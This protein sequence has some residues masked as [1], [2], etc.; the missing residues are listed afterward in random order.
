LGVEKEITISLLRSLDQKRNRNGRNNTLCLCQMVSE[1]T[2][3]KL[4]F[5]AVKLIFAEETDKALKTED[6]FC[7]GED[8]QQMAKKQKTA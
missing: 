5:V 4:N 2:I 8:P 3:N 7:S 1:N 6:M